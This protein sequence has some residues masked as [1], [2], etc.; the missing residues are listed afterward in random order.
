MTWREVK[1]TDAGAP[2]VD[3]TVGSMNTAARAILK[4]GFGA[5]PGFGWTEPFA[6]VGNVAGFKASAGLLQCYVNINDSAP[7]A[8]PFNDARECRIKPSEAASA[9]STQT[10]LF[11][12]AAQA[13]NG[14]IIRKSATPDGTARPWFAYGD[15][16]TWIM[17]IKSG[18][19]ANAWSGFYIGEYFSRKA[20][21]AFNGMAIGRVV[22]QI[23]ATPTAL[24]SQEPLHG[25]AAPGTVVGGHFV[26][27]SFTEAAQSAVN[28]NKH[29]AGEHSASDLNGIT[30]FPNPVDGAIDLD[31]LKV[32]ELI[33]P[34][35][36][37]RGRLR[38]LYH[39]KHPV[40]F[41][42]HNDVFNGVGQF[43]GKSFRIIGP[44]PN[45]LG[46]FVVETS[47]T[48]DTN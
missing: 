40:N 2:Q 12:T 30:A 36:C 15:G 39:F 32:S 44:T 47:D 17:F 25:L 42:N 28:V 10:G 8:A 38:G 31:Y 41:V 43:A 18:D 11:P 34:T 48:V 26:A 16:R 29:G 9:L 7:R 35:F 27:R 45:G 14:L 19:Y 5:F 21:D 13:A 33:T 1:S 6:S 4:T 46:V 3:G 23:A 20:A 24:P 37:N 22:E